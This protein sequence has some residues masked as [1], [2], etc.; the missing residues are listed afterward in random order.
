MEEGKCPECG[1]SKIY[2][3]SNGDILCS[4]CGLVIED[5]TIDFPVR[6]EEYS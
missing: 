2:S 5:N 6:K 4:N 3:D 1:S